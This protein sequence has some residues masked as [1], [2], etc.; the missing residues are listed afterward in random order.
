MTRALWF[1]AI[2]GVCICEL[3][4]RTLKRGWPTA[5]DLFAGARSNVLGRLVLVIGW[6][7]LGW[8]VFAR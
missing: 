6:I 1:V 7:W 8:H 2:G 3:A 4:S 5:A